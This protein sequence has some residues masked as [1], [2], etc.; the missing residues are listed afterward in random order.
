MSV[1]AAIVRVTG[2][3]AATVEV[4]C[5]L[6]D[7]NGLSSVAFSHVPRNESL[8]GPVSST[9][10]SPTVAS[11]CECRLSVKPGNPSPTLSPDSSIICGTNSSWSEVRASASAIPKYTVESDKPTH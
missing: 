3:S 4:T 11:S 7:S 9:L 6:T 5:N 1:D 8:L 2:A 10:A